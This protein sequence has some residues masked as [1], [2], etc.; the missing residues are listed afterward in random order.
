MLSFEL[1][2]MEWSRDE[3][4]ICANRGFRVVVFRGFRVVV[5]GGTKDEV[6][7]K[8]PDCSVHVR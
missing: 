8:G 2:I 1:K 3:R 6:E 4:A 7:G 5:L